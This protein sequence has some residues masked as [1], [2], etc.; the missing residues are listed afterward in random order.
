[1]GGDG[2]VSLLEGVLLVVVGGGG[3]ASVVRSSASSFSTKTP[4]SS[5]CVDDDGV[6]TFSSFSSF[7][8]SCSFTVVGS[9]TV[10]ITSTVRLGLLGGESTTV[11]PW[12]K[13]FID[14]TGEDE[15]EDV[16]GGTPAA[17]SGA[18]EAEEEVDSSFSI[19]ISIDSSIVGNNRG[20]FTVSSWW[21][22]LFYI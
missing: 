16:G 12:N 9:S 5:L 17:S 4:D 20:S 18:E 19:S 11:N 6:P 22:L 8:S 14:F 2:F 1:M 21:L 3:D 15:D 10:R 13:L 7:S